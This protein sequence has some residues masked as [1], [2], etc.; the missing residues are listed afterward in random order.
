M[1]AYHKSNLGQFGESLVVDLDGY[2][3]TTAKEWLT[4]ANL[5]GMVQSDL[6]A[7]P[8]YAQEWANEQAAAAVES[9]AKSEAAVAE[10][11]DE[12]A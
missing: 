9:L 10:W 4:K 2:T 3:Y 7:D 11:Q 6:D 12:D 8:E 5:D 1:A